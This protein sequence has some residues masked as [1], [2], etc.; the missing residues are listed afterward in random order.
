MPGPEPRP[1]MRGDGDFRSRITGCVDAFAELGPS[2][3]LLI[4]GN[5]FTFSCA[6]QLLVIVLKH[7]LRKQ[8]MR[9]F[10][11]IAIK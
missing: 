2:M 1:S 10:K 7:K 5:L 6:K 9:T 8:H 11:M 3:N 4:L